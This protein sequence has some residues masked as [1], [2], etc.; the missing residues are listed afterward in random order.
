MTHS[1][2]FKQDFQ[3]NRNDMVIERVDHYTSTISIAVNDVLFQ[4]CNIKDKHKHNLLTN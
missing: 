1:I 2:I 4:C 3:V